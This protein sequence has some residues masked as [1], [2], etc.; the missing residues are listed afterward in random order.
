MMEAVLKLSVRRRPGPVMPIGSRQETS[1]R[2]AMGRLSNVLARGRRCGLDLLFPPRCAYC[3][4]EFPPVE[5][6]LPLCHE[7]REALAPE[8]WT[9]CVR[10]GAATSPDEPAPR[11]CEMC[12][13]E[14]LKFDTVVSMGDYRSELGRAVLTMKQSAGDVLS[15]AVGRLYWLRRGAEVASLRPDV[16]IPAPMFWA[17]RL[18]RGTNSPDILAESLARRLRVPLVQGT[19]IRSRNTLPQS[20]LRPGPRFA[21]VRRAF[22][23]RATYDLSGLRVVLVDDILTTGA[24]ASEIAALLKRAGASMVAVAV[25]ARGVGCHTY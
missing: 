8:D 21:N 2:S 10:C 12:H 16:V 20:S 1:I 25:L 17:R 13:T 18:A 14:P 6:D 3:D 7:C 19:L 15:A 24:T 23:L 11:S 5:D 9:Y 4:A 22:R